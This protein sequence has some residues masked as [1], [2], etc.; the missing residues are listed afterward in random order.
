MQVREAVCTNNYVAYFKLYA[1]APNMGRALMDMAAPTMRWEALNTLVRALKFSAA[2]PF[3]A[4]SLGFATRPEL[5]PEAALECQ[6][7][8]GCEQSLSRP[9]GLK[10]SPSCPAEAAGDGGILCG[11]D[12]VAGTEGGNKVA[13][14]VLVVLPG[15][16]QAVYN[17][18]YHP[19]VPSHAFHP[20]VHM[21]HTCAFNA[22]V[23]T[24]YR[25]V[26]SFQ[27]S[28]RPCFPVSPSR[29]SVGTV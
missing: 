23:V 25:L 19:E 7:D 14:A 17:G 3:I 10:R 6:T 2:V 8:A 5:P 9:T 29:I 24:L 11:A 21:L 15:S 16:S 27:I 22:Q 20:S 26:Y 1:S 18:K 28:I 12:S 13:E 4:R